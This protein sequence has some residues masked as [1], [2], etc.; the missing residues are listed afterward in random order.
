MAL[1]AEGIWPCTVLSANYGEDPKRPG[2]TR[3]QI[4]A[5]IDEGPSKGQFCTYEDDVTQRSALYIN[6]SCKNVG[7]KGGPSGDD[8]NTLAADCAAWIAETG[9]KALIEI[10]HIRIGKGKRAGETWDKPNSIRRGAA[11]LRPASTTALADAREA[12]RRAIE[13]D[14]GD[15]GDAPPADAPPADNIPHAATGGSSGTVSD[16]EIPF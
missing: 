11:H 16:D 3:V 8:L 15:V 5:I 10:K 13:D 12:M 2:V 4:S 1:K 6:R 14:G 7:W 9:G